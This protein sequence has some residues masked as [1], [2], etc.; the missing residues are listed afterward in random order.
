MCTH[1][2]SLVLSN[3]LRF[4]GLQP[5][6]FLCPWD[7]PGKNAGVGCHALLQGIFPTQR[8]NP[9]L[10][11]LLHWHEVT[12][13]LVPPGKPKNSGVG[14]YFLLQGIFQTPGVEPVSPAASVLQANSLSLS[15]WGS[16][17]LWWKCYPFSLVRLFAIPWT[18]AHWAPLSMEF[19]REEY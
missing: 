8:W 3:S 19:Y 2:K 4:C 16:P 14:C 11:F 13:P 1:A 12:L 18:I 9:C 5:S 15:H 10:L 17:K 7:S 6:R